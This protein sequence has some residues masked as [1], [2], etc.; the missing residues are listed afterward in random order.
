MKMSKMV[1]NVQNAV[2]KSEIWWSDLRYKSVVT[3]I[4]R[5]TLK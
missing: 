2:Y 4:T 5:I 1:V 3:Y